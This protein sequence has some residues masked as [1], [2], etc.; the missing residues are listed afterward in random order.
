MPSTRSAIAKTG[1]TV[2]KKK[3]TTKAK[4]AVE[5]E[6]ADGS[7]KAEENVKQ[8]KGAED[9]VDSLE[10]QMVELAARKKVLVE[11]AKCQ[12]VIDA[13]IARMDRLNSGQSEETLDPVAKGDGKSRKRKREEVEDSDSGVDSEESESSDSGLSL[14]SDESSDDE[15]SE[16]KSAKKHKRRDKKQQGKK[17][18]VSH[19]LSH[20]RREAKA[21]GDCDGRMEMRRLLRLLRRQKKGISTKDLK[22]FVEELQLVYI[23][24][25]QCG[26]TAERFRINRS[27]GFSR[28]GALDMKE[29]REAVKQTTPTRTEAVPK[30]PEER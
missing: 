14:G 13:A 26:V 10:D 19:V 3:S 5:K 9:T 29:V 11:K 2:S 24:S 20:W 18:R 22:A 16:D 28:G 17:L 27:S 15:S 21:L 30:T 6:S 1:S 12:E 25:T 4:P 23:K 7:K 8:R